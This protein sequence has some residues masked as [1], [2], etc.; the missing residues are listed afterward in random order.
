[1]ESSTEAE[2]GGLFENFQKST[3][4]RTAL[5]KM[6]HP[7]PPTLVATENTAAKII[8]NGTE[9]KSR[10]IDMRFYWFRDRIKQNYFH[11]LWEEGK[12]I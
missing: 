10:S 7:Q 1:M 2:L 8:I 9:K 5:A 6:V 4:T 12:K 3:S 11:I